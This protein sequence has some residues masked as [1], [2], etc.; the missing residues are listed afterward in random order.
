MFTQAS[1]LKTEENISHEDVTS[2]AE[3]DNISLQ[4]LT[5]GDKMDKAKR[6]TNVEIQLN[7]QVEIFEQLSQQFKATPNRFLAEAIR[8]STTRIVS[9]H[10]E[11]ELLTAQNEGEK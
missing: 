7:A 8:H 11:A 4:A 3:S 5:R 9:L 2:S 6:L 10:E 1:A